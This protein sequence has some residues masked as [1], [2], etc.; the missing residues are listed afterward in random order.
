M[1]L[2]TSFVIKKRSFFY[3]SLSAQRAAHL[4]PS[5]CDPVF[6]LARPI[7]A[8]SP[9]ANCTRPPFLS[10]PHCWCGPTLQS[11]TLGTRPSASC[12]PSSSRGRARL[13]S[14][15][16]ICRLPSSSD[17]NRLGIPPLAFLAAPQGY[18]SEPTAPVHF[19]WATSQPPPRSR[20]PRA[21]YWRN[22]L[23]SIT[24]IWCRCSIESTWG[25]QKLE[26]TEK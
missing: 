11:L 25:Y 12:H 22:K 15:E 10:G 2:Q 13:C 23:N 24:L 3:L 26:E 9:S 21:L 18:K 19:L 6:L 16:I 14:K 1:V 7:R 20:V 5:S 4:P 17:S 8:G